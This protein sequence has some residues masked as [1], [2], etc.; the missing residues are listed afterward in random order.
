ML[1]I[2]IKGPKKSELLPWVLLLHILFLLCSEESVAILIRDD[3]RI[4]IEPFNVDLD[5]DPLIV[6]DEN[7]LRCTLMVVLRSEKVESSSVSAHKIKHKNA[8][9][10][11]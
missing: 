11:D 2:A 5:C 6:R 9:K 8:F 10:F 3:D 1:N 7:H 4:P